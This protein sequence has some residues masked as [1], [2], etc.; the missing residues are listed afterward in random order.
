[1]SISEVIGPRSL[2]SR[3]A[4]LRALAIQPVASSGEVLALL[5]SIHR[6]ILSADLEHYNAAEIKPDVPMLRHDLFRLREELRGRVA[7]WH[8]AKLMNHQNQLAMRECLRASRFASDMLGELASGFAGL[9]NGQ[10]PSKAFTGNGNT[11][12]AAAFDTDELAKYRAGDVVLVRGLHHNSA[13]IARIGDVDSQFSHIC[14]VHID[15]KGAQW[16]VESLIEEGAVITRLGTALAHGNGRAILFRHRD[17]ELAA[18]AGQI[19]YD[20]VRRTYGTWKRRIL[21]DFSMRLDKRRQLFCSKLIRLAYARASKG[22]LMLPSF[23]TRFDMTN[24]DFIDRIGVKAIETYAPGDIEI[25]PNFDLVA[26]WQ[27]FR[28]TS[29]LRAQDLIMV[30]L[31]EWM[32]DYGYKFEQDFL[33]RIIS[34]FGRFA[35]HL[36]DGAK[37]MLA[38]VIPKV[39]RNMPRRTIAAI[40]M[41]HKTAEPL[42]DEIRSIEAEHIVRTGKPMHPQQV[43]AALEEIRRRSGD[44]IGYLVLPSPDRH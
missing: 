40:A 26:E 11:I 16:V 5:R 10:S 7:I 38:A 15:K 3:I 1:M 27:D 31:F 29:R 4:S 35:A 30:K 17:R 20:H 8:A 37:D 41:L 33:I 32:E 42:L 6:A 43:Y 12:V 2:P 21:Y 22:R 39:P 28:V 18:K 25:E 9:E 19:A 13:A 14:I 44:R 36:S 23:M 34:L 24:R